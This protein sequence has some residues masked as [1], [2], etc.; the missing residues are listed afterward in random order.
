MNRCQ[1]PGCELECSY[2]FSLLC[3]RHISFNQHNNSQEQKMMSHD[4]QSKCTFLYH[5]FL[6]NNYVIIILY[7]Q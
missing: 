6:K 3:Q 4:G 5:F 7:T 1:Y 2:E